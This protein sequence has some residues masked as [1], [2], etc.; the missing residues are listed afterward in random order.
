MAGI[1]PIRIKVDAWN[2]ILGRL[3]LNE[4]K[5]LKCADYSIATRIQR[6]VPEWPF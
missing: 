5:N 1:E 6:R 3:F 2:E 4:F